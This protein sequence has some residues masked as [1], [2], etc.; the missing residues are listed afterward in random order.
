MYQKSSL[1]KFVQTA[2]FTVMPI[3]SVYAEMSGSL[4]PKLRHVK[5]S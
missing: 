5:L 1:N 3:I 2:F 4:C